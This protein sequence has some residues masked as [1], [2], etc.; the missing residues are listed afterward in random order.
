[1][2][3]LVWK[4]CNESLGFTYKL[5]AKLTDIL[6]SFPA[7]LAFMRLPGR[8]N[9]WQLFLETVHYRAEPRLKRSIMY[10]QLASLSKLPRN[11]LHNELARQHLPPSMRDE[12]M[13]RALELKRERKAKKL[14]DNKHAALWHRLIAPLKYELNNAKVG[15]RLKS[16]DTDP[17]RYA[18][19][20][21]YVDVMEK[22]LGGIEGVRL[23]VRGDQTPGDF[24]KT[25]GYPNAGVHW[26]D[27]LSEKTKAR[28]ILLFEAIPYRAKA[29]RFVPFARRMPPSLYDAEQARLWLRTLN[30]YDLLL[31]EL[32]VETDPE[33]LDKL[34]ARRKRMLFALDKIAYDDKHPC[35]PFTWHGTHTPD[36]WAQVDAMQDPLVLDRLNETYHEALADLLA[37]ARP[38]R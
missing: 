24:A 8:P 6:D 18:A 10:K 38:D 3:T 31:S 19:F 7:E 34:D 25:K 29:K 5:S 23:A 30:E 21:A 28:V 22:L 33:R 35:L 11:Q 16:R 4:T 15:A 12:L 1:M 13:T 2:H 37:Q 14:R 32:A 26:S 36:E 27:W 9:Y 17:E 20:Q